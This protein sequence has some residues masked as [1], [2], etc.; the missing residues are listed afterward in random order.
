VPATTY[1][2]P[3]IETLF[4]ALTRR[5]PH[6]KART[7]LAE[8]MSLATM[9]DVLGFTAVRLATAMLKSGEFDITPELAPG[10]YIRFVN[11]PGS[12]LRIVI[13]DLDNM[14][15]IAPNLDHPIPAGEV[16]VRLRHE[17]ATGAAQAIHDPEQKPTEWL[18]KWL[19]DN[20]TAKR[21]ARWAAFHTQFPDV[22]AK[23][24]DT[25]IW[26]AARLL[27]GLPPRGQPGAPKGTSKKLVSAK[28]NV[29]GD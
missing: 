21:A 1:T 5:Y 29:R 19:Q 27:T 11:P 22:S 7:M 28:K 12:N 6:E 14:R 2:Q 17:V 26:R 8:G 10:W 18:H 20:K 3:I 4:K 23:A 24:F 25:R 13:P 9:V 16:W 15:V